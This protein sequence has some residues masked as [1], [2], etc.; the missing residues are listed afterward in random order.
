MPDTG[1]RKALRSPLKICGPGLPRLAQLQEPNGTCRTHV[2]FGCSSE[3]RAMF[4]SR[5]GAWN[6]VLVTPCVTPSTFRRVID[7][8]NFRA[9]H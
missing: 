2:L 6:P 4:A 8:K 1:G 3:P 9:S 7:L 5:G